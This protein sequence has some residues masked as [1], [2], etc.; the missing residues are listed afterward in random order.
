MPG[1]TTIH[2]DALV[3]LSHADAERLAT[4]LR[5]MSRMSAGAT[6]SGA[7]ALSDGQLAALCRGKMDRGEFA[8]WSG[9]L[10]EYLKGHL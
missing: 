5:E 6:G 4:M 1:S 3:M 2:T 8:E 7:E 10:S 9:K